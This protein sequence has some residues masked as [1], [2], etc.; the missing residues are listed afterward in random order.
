MVSVPNQK[1]LLAIPVVVT[2]VN[3][4]FNNALAVP[5]SNKPVLA[6]YQQLTQLLL[7]LPNTVV[8]LNA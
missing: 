6:L 4:Q 7:A 5:T 1:L 3:F 8:L 2:N